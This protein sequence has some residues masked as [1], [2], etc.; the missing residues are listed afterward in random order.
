MPLTTPTKSVIMEH[1]NHNRIIAYKG[2]GGFCLAIIFSS[3]KLLY[4]DI[5]HA[6]ICCFLKLACE[7]LDLG[8]SKAALRLIFLL[9][10]LQRWIK[11]SPF[12]LNIA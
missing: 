5:C 7:K 1:C 9:K 6:H 3:S 2:E 4:A 8:I 10:T 11:P 12:D